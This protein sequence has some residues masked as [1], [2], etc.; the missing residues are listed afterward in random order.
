[1]LRSLL[2]SPICACAHNMEI[3]QVMSN[4]FKYAATVQAYVQTRILAFADDIRKICVVAFCQHQSSSGRIKITK[5][6]SYTPQQLVSHIFTTH[7][8][9][10]GLNNH[11]RYLEGH[12][13]EISGVTFP[14]DAHGRYR[15]KRNQN[16]TSH[17]RR[18]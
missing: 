2:S 4:K 18:Q 10:T 12:T 14:S 6:F 7:L 16:Y 5:Q 1:M 8:K 9:V 15:N 3:G 17:D 13:N 11:E